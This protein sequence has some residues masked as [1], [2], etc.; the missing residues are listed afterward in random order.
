MDYP[1]AHLMEAL[2]D[3]RYHFVNRVGGIRSPGLYEAALMLLA[4]RKPP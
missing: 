1:Q 3:G 2:V 4:H